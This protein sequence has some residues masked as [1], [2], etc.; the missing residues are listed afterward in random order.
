VDVFRRAHFNDAP[1]FECARKRCDGLDVGFC[2]Q[3]IK[4][5]IEEIRIQLESLCITS[6]Q[7]RLWFDNTNELNAGNIIN[8]KN[9]FEFTILFSMI[10]SQSPTVK[11]PR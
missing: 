8:T 5:W 7:I 1:M 10:L 2:Q 11:N 4:T 9:E 6:D 3:V